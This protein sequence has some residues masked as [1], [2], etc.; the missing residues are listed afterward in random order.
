MKEACKNEVEKSLK[1]SFKLE[2]NEGLKNAL[3]QVDNGKGL[4]QDFE[5]EMNEKRTKVT[6]EL[7]ENE[8]CERDQGK[9]KLSEICGGYR[10]GN[11]LKDVGDGMGVQKVLK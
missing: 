9:E 11:R 3:E 7:G 5:L 4:K 1:G 10:K 6:F 2:E 8:A